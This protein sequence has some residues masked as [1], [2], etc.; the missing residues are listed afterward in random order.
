MSITKENKKKKDR[1]PTLKELGKTAQTK[2]EVHIYELA[3]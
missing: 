3:S 2:V 1:S